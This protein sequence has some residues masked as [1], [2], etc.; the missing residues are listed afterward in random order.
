MERNPKVTIVCPTLNSAKWIDGYLESVNNQLEKEFDII[1]VDAGSNDGSWE[2]ITDYQFRKGISPQYIQ[3]PG[4]SIYEA[5]NIGYSESKTE[6]TMNFNTDDRLY[7]AAIS[8]LLAYAKANP[9]A[10]M[11][12]SS[13]LTVKDKEHNQ[14]VN[15]SMA[16]EMSKETLIANNICGPFPLL[17]TKAIIEAGLFNPKYTISGDY[18]MWL[19]MLSKGCELMNIPEAI[20]TYFFNPEGMSTNRESKHWQEHIK[21]DT[22]IR[23]I[24]A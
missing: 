18:E 2:T 3:E 19:R 16:P 21:Q 9:Q 8:T 12:Y 11:I 10:D 22:E 20:G 7:P 1:F 24:Y 5:W 17:R 13:Y 6:Y 14:I 15:L 4:C 23:R